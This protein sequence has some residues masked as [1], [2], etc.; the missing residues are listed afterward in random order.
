VRESGDVDFQILGPVRVVDSGSDLTPVRPK[1]RALLAMLLLHR[2]QVVPGALLI[3]ALW[4]GAPPGSAQSALHGHVSNLRK[5]LGADRVRT[6]PPGYLLHV[7]SEEL[8]L[9]RFES[10]LAEARRCTDP[11]ERAARLR[12]AL[13]L[14]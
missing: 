9:D 2:D 11:E 6:R 3:E 5:L 7:A 4:S 12:E 10:L 13:A 8:D 14:W 1:Q